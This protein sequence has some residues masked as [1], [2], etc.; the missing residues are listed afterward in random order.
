MTNDSTLQGKATTATK[1]RGEYSL[2]N[3]SWNTTK[4]IIFDGLGYTCCRLRG[5]GYWAQ[6]TFTGLGA[7]YRLVDFKDGSIK[8]IGLRSQSGGEG[9]RF[10]STH[11]TSRLVLEQ[12]MAQGF[13][14]GFVWE[15][16][17]G[18]AIDNIVL[19]NCH[20]PQCGTGFKVIGSNAL[21]P[22]KYQ[23]CTVSGTDKG[24]D[25]SQ[26]GAGA[27]WD[28]CGGS[29][30]G[31]VWVLNGGFEHTITNAV[32]ERAGTVLRIGTLED[33]GQPTPFYFH[34]TQLRDTKGVAFEI[35]KAGK[36]TID[37]QSSLPEDEPLV[38]HACNKNPN[39]PL[40]ISLPGKKAQV[41][42]L[43]SEGVVKV[44]G[45]IVLKK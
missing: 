19:T 33:C 31:T 25:H 8:R 44:D 45:A 9:F 16:F 27:T 17:D 26:G 1:S 30:V 29:D 36:V 39:A 14:V 2:G 42:N 21:S 41:V 35:Y 15:A 6:H 18:A 38:I 34:A 28:H 37:V 13:D 20:A 22:W 11:S 12:V 43:G 23:V 3:Q 4:T 32:T 24:F 40:E 5:S 7:A 10:D